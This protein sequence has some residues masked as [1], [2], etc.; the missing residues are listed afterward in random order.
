MNRQEF[1]KFSQHGLVF[2][3]IMIFLVLID[4]QT[5]FATV[6][7]KIL[8]TNVLR[9]G[10]PEV[11]FMVIFLVL[12]SLWMGWFIS[13]K[14]ENKSRRIIMTLVASL[15]AGVVVGLFGL[16]LNSLIQ[17]GTDV[18]RYLAALSPE[19]MKL[20]LLNL[21]GLG[22][23]ALL[24]VFTVSGLLGSVLSI[25]LQ[26]P[27]VSKWPKTIKTGIS[28]TWQKITG[29]LPPFIRK[30]AKFLAYLV[31]GIVIIVLPTRWGSYNNFVTGLVGLYIILGIGLNIIVGLSGQLV[32]GFA[33]F[34]AM[35][36]YSM[37]I[38]NA[39]LPHGLMWGFWPALL[40]GV[41]M[42]VVA[43]ILLGLPMMRLRGD[44]LA[45]VTLGFGEIIRIL[46][47][48]DLLS[49]F[50]GGPRGIQDIKG[51]TIFGF[52][53]NNDVQ[54]TYLIIAGVILSIFVYK[55]LEN[56]RTGRAWLAI[57]E[58][59]IAARATGINV[60]R[61]KL[62]ALCIGAAF[63]GLA[64]A[65]F[66]AR[67]QFTGPNDHTLMVSINILSIVIVGGMNSIPGIILGAFTLKGLPEILREMENYRLLVF[68]GL[69]VFMMIARPDGLWPAKRPQLEKKIKPD[70][71]DGDT[72]GKGDKNE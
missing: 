36:A 64:G 10:L 26:S 41:L 54:F 69:L 18:R 4:F 60:Q 49:N 13:R 48:S 31:L 66:A 11:Q 24:G 15:S 45:I 39:P 21:E 59:A 3:I 61:N 32:L 25:I 40:V 28:S 50:S 34:F 43:A 57:K 17:S 70:T 23:L 29:S 37:A 65:I 53:F 42:A 44:Y 55:R 20:F 71:R 9:G 16:I 68:G 38:L 19:S 67:N 12:Y 46:L 1:Q 22:P 5:M 14:E 33:A 30:N 58:D 8:G 62:L 52:P 2:A 47:K 63:A 35:G 7:S 27:S 6:I 72:P 51:P 56:S